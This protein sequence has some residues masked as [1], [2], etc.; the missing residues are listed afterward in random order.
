MS[1]YCSCVQVETVSTER[2]DL[3][4]LSPDAIEALLDGRRSDVE[5]LG[6]FALPDEWP[7]EHD[8]GF[9]AFRRRQMAKDGNE[10]RW[11]VRAV[12]LRDEGRPMIGHAG[13]HGSPGKNARADPRA[14][15]LGYTIFE[16]YRRRGYAGEAVRA[17]IHWAE[18]EG[19]DRFI[20]SIGPDNVPSLALVRRLGFREVG[21]HWDDE[22]GEE[23]E[24]EL[25]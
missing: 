3:V 22:D 19:I 18:G 23:L 20:A 9:L 13:F 8:R 16:P 1:P 7:D 12:V 2:L 4:W 15:E 11:L 5:L 14:L 17:L 24:F 10:A 21:R 6:G 25:P